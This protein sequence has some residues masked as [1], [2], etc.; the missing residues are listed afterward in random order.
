MKENNDCKDNLKYNGLKNTKQRTAILEIL[1]NSNQ[2]ISAEQIYFELIEKK[3]S[4]SLS[5][6]YRA[7]EIMVSKELVTKLS[8][9]GDNKALFELNRMIHKHYLVCLGCKKIL[10]INH[11]ALE[12]YEEALAKE[13]NFM[14]V[15]HKLDIYGY[16]PECKIK[17]INEIK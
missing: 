7:V 14:I 13:T 15:G 12:N 1:E 5:T 3:I 10:A 4:V 11:C 8:I 17:L 2:P 6:V 16:C 9:S